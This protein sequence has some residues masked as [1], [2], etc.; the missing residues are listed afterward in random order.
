MLVKPGSVCRWCPAICSTRA[1]ASWLNFSNCSFFYGE[2]V[3]SMKD[4]SLGVARPNFHEQGGGISAEAVEVH[5]L[6]VIQQ[7]A[8][9]FEVRLRHLIECA[10]IDAFKPMQG[11]C[12]DSNRSPN[13]PGA[14]GI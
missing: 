6:K 9:R 7:A 5:L 10:D 2:S 12:I 4:S 8:D 3:S 13:K 1:S 11:L 14:E